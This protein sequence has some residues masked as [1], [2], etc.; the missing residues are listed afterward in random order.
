[1][2]D[3]LIKGIVIKAVTKDKDAGL[4]TKTYLYNFPP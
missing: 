4:N 2:A 1:M 3:F